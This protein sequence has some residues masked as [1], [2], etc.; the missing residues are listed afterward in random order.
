MKEALP[1][2]FGRYEVVELV[3]TGAMGKVYK[4]RDPNIDRV[5]AIKVIH[6]ELVSQSKKF[7]E[8]FRREAQTAGQITHP[9]IVTVYDVGLE[10]TSSYIVMEFLDGRPLSDAIKGGLMP[11]HII[12][13]SIQICDAL[14][15]AHSHGL[16]HR[17]IKPENIMILPTGQIKIT[18][19][20]L[21]RLASSPHLT[22]SGLIS[23]TP[24]YMAP[25]QIQGQQLDGRT[26]I[27]ALGCVMYEMIAGQPPFAGNNI[28]TVLYRIMNEDP[29]PS[30]RLD[31]IAPQMLKSIVLRALSKNRDQR[32]QTC[33]EIAQDLRQCK[34]IGE[35]VGMI[36]PPPPP[37]TIRTAVF[38]GPGEL[39]AVNPFT[40][41]NPI[42]DPTR[43]FGRQREIEQVFS[44]LRNPAFESSSIV[45]ERRVGKTS[46]LRVMAHP[47]VV[48]AHGLDPD[49]HIFVYNDLSMVGESTKPLQLWL[50][51]LR[52]IRRQVQDPNPELNDVIAELRSSGQVDNYL[53]ADFFDLL[54]DVGLS[55]VLLLDEFDTIT[56]NENFG[57]DFFGVLRS[58]AIHHDLA[59]ITSSRQELVD[60]CH[61]DEVRTS[62]FFNIFANINLRGMLPAEVEQMIDHLLSETGV[63]FSDQEKRAI[64]EISGHHPFFTQVAAHF[65]W[66]ACHDQIEEDQR[67]AYMRQHF[68]AESDPHFSDYCQ[69]S[70]ENEHIVLTALAL[71]G[72][73]NRRGDTPCEMQEIRQA[74]GRLDLVAG[75]LEKRSLVVR[76]E[77]EPA[78]FSPAF[79]DW[80]VGEVFD[81]VGTADHDFQSWLGQQS[82]QFTPAVREI[83][84]RINAEHRLWVGK[85]LSDDDGA[86]F[87]A[88]VHCLVDG[89]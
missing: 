27:F 53:L 83:L 20:G 59:L 49:S 37:E 65:L 55:V 7:L 75:Q 36:P 72:V 87:L 9:N 79:E 47:D 12:D 89:A 38:A 14:E 17:D 29:A 16:V 51:L 22:Q 39:S 84:P 42:T 61:S 64:I 21:A 54:S 5:V 26:D 60:L 34:Q 68:D 66:D 31:N 19:F 24:S 6:A 48:R 73:L 50:R 15:Y 1:E 25:E 81:M 43:F 33:A 45:G 57:P 63:T 86:G 62:P 10:G 18:D 46:L 52:T 70:T 74:F 32:Y 80:V 71:R 58:L 23:G 77:D 76:R 40:Y 85:W 13:F 41:G 56:Y 2:R 44:R 30:E 88:V 8:R 69:H 82:V 11:E 4:A 3:G 35:A 67:V 78:L 28:G